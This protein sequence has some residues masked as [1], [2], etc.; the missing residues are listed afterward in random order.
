[1]LSRGSEDR[2]TEYVF[3]RIYVHMVS[4]PEYDYYAKRTKIS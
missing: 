3:P 2:D 1:M 4:K